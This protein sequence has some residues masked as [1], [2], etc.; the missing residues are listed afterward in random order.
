MNRRQL[1]KLGVPRDCVAVAVNALQT[2]ATQKLG[3][4]LKGKRAKQLVTAVV[5]APENYTDDP[6][7]SPL[8]IAMQAVPCSVAPQGLLNADLVRR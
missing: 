8:A 7:W 5:A 4:G 3:M 1:Q 2:A 6:I